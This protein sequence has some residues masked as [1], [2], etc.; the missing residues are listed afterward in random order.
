MT[1]LLTNFRSVFAMVLIW[2]ILFQDW[3]QLKILVVQHGKVIWGQQWLLPS[4][5]MSFISFA[6]W[7]SCIIYS[8]TE[9]G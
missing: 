1:L 8:F 6:F 5:Q 4:H 3:N 7:W 9:T 2:S